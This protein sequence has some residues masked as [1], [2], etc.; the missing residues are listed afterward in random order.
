MRGQ[1]YPLGFSVMQIIKIVLILIGI[2]LLFMFFPTVL[3]GASD[4]VKQKF[5]GG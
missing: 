5:V 4:W 2:L 3:H 1:I